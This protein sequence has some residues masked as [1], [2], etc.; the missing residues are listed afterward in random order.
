MADWDDF[1]NCIYCNK[2][3]TSS[4]R[5]QSGHV[6][7]EGVSVKLEAPFDPVVMDPLPEDDLK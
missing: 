4:N 6:P 7:A 1:G 5:H 3:T 2:P